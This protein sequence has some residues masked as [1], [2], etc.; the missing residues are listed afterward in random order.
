[1]LSRISTVIQQEIERMD[2]RS[3]ISGIV[4]GSSAPFLF[5][6]CVTSFLANRKLN[7]GVLGYGRIANSM[8][9]PTKED[10]FVDYV[11]SVLQAKVNECVGY[12]DN[13]YK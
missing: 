1:M 6:G 13:Y 12:I 9:V 11:I 4:A 7:V 5:N 10:S 2:R 8:D 3:F